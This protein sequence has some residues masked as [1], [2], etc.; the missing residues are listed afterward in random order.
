V[1]GSFD[2]RTRLIWGAAQ[3]F[4]ECRTYDCLSAILFCCRTRSFRWHSS[5][6]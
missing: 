4:P 1:V 5:L 3:C 2:V 6:F